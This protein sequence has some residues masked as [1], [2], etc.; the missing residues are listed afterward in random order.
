[1]HEFKFRRAL[2]YLKEEYITQLLRI[3]QNV[4]IFQR[5]MAKFYPHQRKEHIAWHSKWISFNYFR[6]RCKFILGLLSFLALF[7][8]GIKTS[9]RRHAVA[10]FYNIRYYKINHDVNQT[11][12][13]KNGRKGS[14]DTKSGSPTLVEI[15]KYLNHS[16]I[17]CDPTQTGKERGNQWHRRT[18]D[19]YLFVDF[20]FVMPEIAPKFE[21]TQKIFMLVLVNSGAKGDLF[22]KRRAV[23]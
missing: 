21:N 22:R 13:H 9:A 20:K 15:N 2:L 4:E 11:Q 18:N 6:R 10:N 1:M 16:K 14:V 8:I 23:I 12:S 7:H 19:S 17:F 5:N 3:K